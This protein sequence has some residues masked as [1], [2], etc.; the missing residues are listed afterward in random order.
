MI[1][2]P[3]IGVLHVLDSSRRAH[4]LG[5]GEKADVQI[6]A[7]SVSRYHAI[8]VVQS[9]GNQRRVR[10]DDNGSTNG[11]KVNGE[12]LKE[13]W[14]DS[15][16]KLRLGDVLLRFQWMSDDEIQYASGVSSK[17]MQAAR[18]PL[19]GLLTRAFVQDRLPSRLY[20]AERRRQSVCCILL[21]LDHFKRIN[22]DHGH[23][24]GDAVIRR[25]SK[26]I[27]EALRTTD[28]AVRYGG[29]E[30]LVVL[31]NASLTEAAETAGRLRITIRGIDFAD[32]VPQLCVTASQGIALRGR[33]EGVD[34]WIERADSAL[35]TAKSGGRDRV[36]IASPSAP[37]AEGVRTDGPMFE[38]ELEV[39]AGL[40]YEGPPGDDAS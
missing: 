19:T 20:E 5:R 3:G 21:D 15:G 6:Q 13:A 28:L 8:A 18:D 39:K 16:D 31:M 26:A 10:I 27:S 12:S 2:G 36:H 23:L 1:E 40:T 7:P 4:R 29:E 9:D 34:D 35:Y 30:F 14:L 25:A 32:L 38:T 33:N 17:L 11:I 24:V 37:G 22:D